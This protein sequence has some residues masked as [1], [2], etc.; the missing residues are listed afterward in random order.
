[1]ARVLKQLIYSTSIQLIA[2]PGCSKD[3][4]ITRETEAVISLPAN[5]E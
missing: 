3:N 4:V 5:Q 1:M 2:I